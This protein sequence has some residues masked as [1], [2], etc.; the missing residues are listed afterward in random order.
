MTGKK[1]TALICGMAKSGIASAILLYRNGYNVTI[2]DMKA[3]IPGL[4]QALSH[5]EYKNELG[6]APETLLEGVD[7][8]VLSPVIPIFKP[9]ALKAKEM[10]IEVIG[11]I[12]LGYRFCHRGSRFVCISGT[13]GKTTTTALTGELFRAAGENTFVLGNI[14]IP[15]TEKTMEVG[16][17]DTVV[18]EVAALQ[19][20]S[21]AEFRPNA[22]GMLNITEDHLNR[23]QYKWKT[24]S[25][26]SAGALKTR[27]PMTLPC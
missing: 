6:K 25:P 24:T 23:F 22:F 13:N 21:I 19:L 1:K 7:L 18:A 14:G 26:Q 16:D 27:P 10:G 3:E 2:N 12:E 5:I 9:F 8:L 4:E 20:E 15:I 11:E 17:G